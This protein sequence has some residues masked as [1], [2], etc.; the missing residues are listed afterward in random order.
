M[1]EEA[2]GVM[3]E[4]KKEEGVTEEEAV[5]AKVVMEEEAK[6]AK[7]EGVMEEEAKE[8]EVSRFVRQ[9]RDPE[10]EKAEEV[11]VVVEVKEVEKAEEAEVE[12]AEEVVVEKAE[13]GC[14]HHRVNFE[15]EQ[16]GTN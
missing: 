7:A 14:C 12:K 15:P 8:E 2:E 6:E 13:A 11:A 3:E 16:S 5:E 1:L 9:R 10:V 4:E